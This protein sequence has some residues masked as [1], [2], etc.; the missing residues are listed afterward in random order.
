MLC[1][2]AQIYNIP[3]AYLLISHAQ[4][5]HNFMPFLPW[6]LL[7]K[8][9]APRSIPVFQLYILIEACF[10]H[11]D[12]LALIQILIN[13]GVLKPFFHILL[14]ISLFIRDHSFLLCYIGFLKHQWNCLLTHIQVHLLF[15]HQRHLLLRQKRI[16]LYPFFY[17]IEDFILLW[18]TDN[19]CLLGYD[20][21][22]A[23][24]INFCQI[25]LNCWAT[26]AVFS[27]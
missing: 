14:G 19:S 18:P 8:S 15:Y 17:E 26:Y 23:V 16:L 27:N 21:Y 4:N 2:Y 22:L 20:Q 7:Q 6:L 5:N 12:N 3:V 25:A 24:S 1:L 11:K 9:L 10:I 13:I